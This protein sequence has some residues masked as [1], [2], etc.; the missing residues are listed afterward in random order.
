MSKRTSGLG[1][2]L[3]DL[4]ADNSPEI[5]GGATVVRRNE[6]G[7]A[8]ITPD[9]SDGVEGGIVTKIYEN[10]VV[11]D[12]KEVANDVNEDRIEETSVF[13]ESEVSAEPRIII[14]GSSN[15]SSTDPYAA[16]TV[17]GA[18]GSEARPAHRS[19]KALFKS[20]K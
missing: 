5:R 7:E 13:S 3:G 12:I 10:A 4:L 11:N 14:G 8:V 2:G 1:R 18:D 16:S 19:L 15:M 20:Y 6:D 9:L 17:S